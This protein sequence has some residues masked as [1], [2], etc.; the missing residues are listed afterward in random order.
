MKENSPL[1]LADYFLFLLIDVKAFLLRSALQSPAAEAVSGV[2]GVLPVGTDAAD[3]CAA[4]VE[5]L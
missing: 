1:N 3:A 4:V 2:V 5:C